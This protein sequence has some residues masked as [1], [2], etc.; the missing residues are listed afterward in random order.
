MAHTWICARSGVPFYGRYEPYVTF[1]SSG[2][3]LGLEREFFFFLSGLVVGLVVDLVVGFV[4]G[5]VA[6]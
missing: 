1:G 5:F 4:V 3:G 6:G 2:I